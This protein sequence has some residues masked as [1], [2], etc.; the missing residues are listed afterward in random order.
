MLK[1]NLKGIKN[2]I[3]VMLICFLMIALKPHSALAEAGL[4]TNWG[5]VF[6]RN[7]SI[8]QTYSTRQLL[9]FPYKLT[10]TGGM[11]LDIQVDIEQSIEGG[12]KDGYEVLPSTSWIHL[13]QDYFTIAP[14]EDALTDV[15]ISVPDD[16]KYLGKKYQFE[17]Y[18]HNATSIG[19]VGL[20]LSSR[21][22]LEIAPVRQGVSLEEMS[23]IRAN[24]NFSIIPAGIDAS[25]IKLG[26]N[27]NLEKLTGKTFKI[28]NPNDESYSYRI[29]SISPKQLGTT[30]PKDYEVCPD[31]SFLRIDKPEMKIQGNGIEKIKIFLKIPDK[32]EYKNKKYVFVVYTEVLNQDIP[33]GKYSFLYVTTEE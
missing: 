12:L 6:L 26:Q 14:K 3:T 5:E 27:Y 11:E 25:A 15:V 10:N 20:G 29:T 13:A 8:G 23:Q 19:L 18:A 30:P 7:V 16:P 2:I 33:V 32:E 17:I 9:N 21:I 4:S 28:I 1:N 24:L 31:A 22:L